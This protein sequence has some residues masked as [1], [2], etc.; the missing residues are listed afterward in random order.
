M[1]KFYIPMNV[2]PPALLPETQPALTRPPQPRQQPPAQSIG[3]N[4]A[5]LLANL[6]ATP[7]YL[8]EAAIQEARQEYSSKLY[9]YQGHSAQSPGTTTGTAMS[10]PAVPETASAFPTHQTYTPISHPYQP[11][12]QITQTDLYNSPVNSGT[13]IDARATIGALLKELQETGSSSPFVSSPATLPSCSST[14]TMSSTS[15]S[16]VTLIPTPQAPISEDYSSGKITPQLL[17]RLASIAETDAQE[18]GPLLWE[19]K[20]LQ[21]RQNMMEMTLFQERQALVEKQKRELVQLQASE[22]MGVDVTAQMQKTRSA[23][24]QELK[25]FDK[26]VIWELDKEVVAVQESLSKAGIPMM[27]RTQDPAMIASQIK[28]LRLLQD[29]LQS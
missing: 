10:M 6:A 5:L 12:A 9:A 16:S 11:Q 13:P 25:Q 23:H 18:G 7:G 4:A 21:E 3:A 19:I 1:S 14:A 2:E 27:S 29:M 17:K 28:V 24:S 26:N 8:S 15:I 20:R 22:I